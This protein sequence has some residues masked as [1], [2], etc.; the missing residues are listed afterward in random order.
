MRAEQAT[1]EPI[2]PHNTHL[3]KHVPLLRVEILSQEF[4]AL[5]D[6]GSTGSLVGA[7]I[8]D[9]INKSNSKINT[10]L[11]AIS[12]AVGN[13]QAAES[14]IL[15]VKWCS[16]SRRQR[17]IIVPN[18]NRPI[19]LGQDFLRATHINV[20]V[21]EGGWTQGLGEQRL[22]PFDHCLSVS[23]T[24]PPPAVSGTGNECVGLKVSMAADKL[25]VNDAASV[26]SMAIQLK[27]S[28]HAVMN[29]VNVCVGDI[30]P[31]DILFNDCEPHFEFDL[32]EFC[33][34]AQVSN[35]VSK[36]GD[37]DIVTSMVESVTNVQI[38]KAE[39]VNILNPFRSMFTSKPGFCSLVEH[40][41][42]T[43]DARPI[44]CH[45]RPMTPAKRT[46]L[47]NLVQQLLELDLIEPCSSPWASAPVLVP[48]DGGGT[49]LA[50]DYR[51][52][53]AV[54][55][56]DAYP[57]HRVD[58]MLCSLANAKIF[59]AF[60]LS[61]GYF[62]ISV[63][64]RD[65]D[66][67]AFHGPDGLYR[68]KRAPFGARNSG[69]SFMR[70]INLA[71]K[72]Q[73]W[74]NVVTFVDDVYVYSSNIEDHIRDIQETL[75]SLKAAGFT[76]NPKKVQLCVN[77]LKL[78]GFIV[79]PG[80]YY[81]D[82]DKLSALEKWEPPQNIRALRRFLG[83][84]N[85]YRHFFEKFEQLARPL[86]HLLKSN[87]QYT[88][89]DSCQVAFNNIRK[90]LNEASCLYMPNLNLP[91]IIQTDS[92]G[93][94]LGA[95]L[96]QEVNSQ[97]HP[98]WFASRSLSQAEKNYSTTE[99][100]CLGV[101]WAVRKFHGF[102]E[103]SQVTIECDHQALSWL[104]RIT[105]P[106]GRLARWALEL[107]GYN[108]HIKYIKG[109]T[110]TAADALSRTDS[111]FSIDIETFTRNELREHQ[112]R[113]IELVPIIQHLKG[114]QPQP[115]GTRR[116]ITT[117]CLSN[118]GVLLKDTGP[119]TQKPWE[120][121]THLKPCIPRTLVPK[122]LRMFH[123]SVLSG[124]MGMRRT[125][126]RIE[127][128]MWWSTLRKDVQ[129]Y[130]L[131]CKVCQRV[132]AP[133]SFKFGIGKS[134]EPKSPWEVVACDTMGPYTEGKHKCK[135]LLVVVDVFT[136]YV[137]LFPLRRA[138]AKVILSKLWTVFL[139]FGFPQ[140]LIS[141]NAKVFSCPTYLQWCLNLKIQP[142]HTAVKKPE[143]NITER[144]NRTI[145]DRIIST[146]QECRDWDTKLQEVAFAV[147][148]AVNASTGYSAAFLNFGR[149]LKLPTDAFQEFNFYFRDPQS[150]ANAVQTAHE[151]AKDSMLQAN[152][153][154]M[155]RYNDGRQESSLK[156]GDRVLVRSQ[157]ISDASKGI[158]A[159]LCPKYHGPF[160][161]SRIQP[162]S[163]C[164]LKT[165]DNKIVGRAH[166]S[167]LKKFQDRP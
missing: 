54:T 165:S 58:D 21:A 164:H 132:K 62:Q 113:D 116:D 163:I 3:P 8:Q 61:K 97:R 161:I 148:T 149:E 124:H 11:R 150:K 9:L 126:Q 142:C 111:C 133:H 30:T 57:G 112:L 145:K 51:K 38:N 154:S 134:M 129:E 136:K 93:G 84:A 90:G 32:A 12:M 121:A 59:T 95:Q 79:V 49:R 96:I 6:T 24:R 81:P 167:K 16:G 157:P 56:P 160:I 152:E 15:S 108:L 139:R 159:A 25:C 127:G 23:Q 158:T 71:L 151:M 43:G 117:Y 115:V 7:D 55:L 42:D 31:E 29:E 78:L 147:N 120:G 27:G 74:R 143:A 37:H 77:E 60:D 110:N 119:S 86:N 47:Q 44:A 131:S 39:L 10:D 5:L 89:S 50:I 36:A 19:I 26:S 40:T 1:V 156:I 22:I 65:R 2:D 107:Q 70:A 137:E 17:F 88:W 91:F 68:F 72:D 140:M 73:L 146:I 130:V 75:A 64:E 53:N 34:H 18:L 128:R 106:V 102:I 69:Q 109:T 105:N 13:C 122:I 125:I 99:Q 4:L 144:Y 41:I 48:K 123:D 100:E 67:T 162:S 114:H 94:G 104:Q 45:P 135:H 14:C 87:V 103:F 85:F 82:P 98:V 153:K 101:I 138:T 155:M 80:K 166:V 141:D 76:I 92:S 83:F 63:A 28:C 46:I 118:D 20:N 66:K 33:A 35:R 52:V